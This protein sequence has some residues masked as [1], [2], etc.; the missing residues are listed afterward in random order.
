MESVS[1]FANSKG[2]TIIC[3]VQE[4]PSL[5]LLGIKNAAKYIDNVW[6]QLHNKD[7]ISYAACASGGVQAVSLNGLELVCIEVPAADRKFRP[8]YVGK[9][10][11]IGTYKR[12]NRGDYCCTEEEVRQ[13]MRDASEQPQ[14]LAVVRSSTIADLEAS[15]ISMYRNIL[16]AR[17][18][19][20]PSLGL[21]IQEFLHSLG[22][23]ND[24][25]PSNQGVTL[26]GALMFGCS[27]IIRRAIP[28]LHLD[29][30]E[31]TSLD[32][33]DRYADR[34]TSEDGTWEPNLFNFYRKVYPRLTEGL[35]APFSLD[36]NA[37]RTAETP[38]HKAVRE[39]L[40]NSLVHTNYH[41]NSS[42]RTCRFRDALTFENPG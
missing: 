14:D 32:P 42:I 12:R 39:A 40:V 41:S 23:W 18:P 28:N 35:K 37:M 29:Y 11:L 36:E 31:R 34:V 3:G 2:G 19:D 20:H 7:V 13:M 10:P 30:L 6:D 22:G 15:S 4:K 8:V 21:S 1:A 27:R 25:D 16:S 24:D 9:N 33:N 17:K 5:A 38:F 26:A